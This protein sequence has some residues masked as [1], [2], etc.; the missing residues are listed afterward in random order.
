[1][2]GKRSGAL[3][4]P[5]KQV[6][7]RFAG[8]RAGRRSRVVLNLATALVTIVFAYFA[9]SGIKLA[10]VWSTLRSI[11]DVWLVPA[12]G[13]FALGTVARGLRWR[14]LFAPERRPPRGAVLNAMTVGYLYNNILPARA[15]EAARVVVLARRSSTPPV[16][17]VTTAVL[18]RLYDIV[19]I[20]AIFFV[21]EPWLPHV[22]WV[23]AAA[24]F[25][26]VVV[27]VIAAAAFLLVVY[28]QRSVRFVLGPLRRFPRLS[29]GRFDRVVDELVHGLSGLRR[30]AVAIEALL[31]TFAAWALSA[32]CAYFVIRAFHL[33]LPFACAVLVIVAVGLSMIL[34]SPPGAIGV[35]EGA[36]LI[37]L[38]AYGVDHSTALSYALV[39]HAV[40]F[41]P[42]ILVGPL[43]LHHNSRNRVV[44]TGSTGASTVDTPSR[45][46]PWPPT[47]EAVGQAPRGAP[48]SDRNPPAKSAP[49]DV[50]V[51]SRR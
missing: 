12:L 37:A 3:V 2:S 51:R 46:A 29:S 5:V 30:G 42:F 9:L 15:G 7:G 8:G 22:N 14:S 33:Q 28:G 1:M 48:T 20:L 18:E 10:T 4:R 23:K 47:D 49:A 6:A 41:V 39:L 17:I 13:A 45:S 34:P 50:S 21:T 31:W 44:R 24:I 38:N 36:A 26:I 25:A 40:N 19:G 32:L 35:F 11:D 27:A 16:E 43:L